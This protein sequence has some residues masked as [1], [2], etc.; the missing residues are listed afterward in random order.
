VQRA[1][2]PNGPSRRPSIRGLAFDHAAELVAAQQ[3]VQEA[4]LGLQLALLDTDPYTITSF[5]PDRIAYDS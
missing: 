3:P 4:C 5:E 2:A 1:R